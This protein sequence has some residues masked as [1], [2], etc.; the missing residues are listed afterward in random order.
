MT[1]FIFLLFFKYSPRDG[2]LKIKKSEKKWKNKTKQNK[3]KTKNNAIYFFSLIVSSA[4]YFI[5]RDFEF[6]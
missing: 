4:Y 1:R 3:T 2:P 5:K 6:T